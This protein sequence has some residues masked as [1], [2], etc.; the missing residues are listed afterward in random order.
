V[1]DR[2]E[3]QSRLQQF[4][5]KGEWIRSTGS[6]GSAGGK[7]YLPSAL[8]VDS[9]GNVWVADTGNNRI[10]EFNEKGE[11]LAVFGKDVNKTKV[12]AAG[13][14]A[15]RNLC[16]AASGNVCKGGVA[17]SAPGQLSGPLGIALT[18]GGNLWVSDTG[19]SRLQK[20]GPTGN[21]INNIS[22]PGSEA[23][24]LKEPTAIT[25]APDG[26]I[27]VADTGNNRIEQWNSSLAFVRAVGKEGSG[28]GEFKAPAA[29][30]ADASGNI[31]V[32][33]TGNNRVQEFG[34]GGRYLGQFGAPGSGSFSLSSPMGIAIGTGGSVWVTDV[35]RSKLQ[36]WRQETPGRKSRR[37]FG[38]T[39]LNRLVYM[40][41]VRRR[42]A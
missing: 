27:W 42:P 40:V 34:E 10:A 17:G 35:G 5:E 26:S 36:E 16:T 1:I 28:G 2:A 29:I 39:A 9:K 4:N 12:E 14:E 20:F 8:A 30:E 38:W 37:S 41:P 18:S 21:L 15:E 7:L 11:F 33:D 22:G 6:P 25:V 32:G 24:R 31:W 23:G 19:N 3:T 13:T